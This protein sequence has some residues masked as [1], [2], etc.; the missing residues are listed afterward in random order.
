MKRLFLKLSFWN[1]FKRKDVKKSTPNAL[2]GFYPI[3]HLKSNIT[4]EPKVVLTS[5][6]ESESPILA[7]RFSES[8]GQS[9]GK[10]ILNFLKNE[11]RAKN[12]FTAVEL[13]NWMGGCL[14]MP[15]I[16]KTLYRMKICGLVTSV[17]KTDD[18]RIRIWKLSSTK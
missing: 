1:Y 16:S 5:K 17:V 9:Y 2:E 12:G 15:S 8:G 7:S 6:D 14:A 3:S 18:G 13:H 11:P 4:N 10:L